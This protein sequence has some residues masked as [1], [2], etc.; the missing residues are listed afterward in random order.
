MPLQKFPVVVPLGGAVDEGTVTEL[1]Q[2]PRIQEAQDC[3]SI[4]GGA[5][6]KRDA[7]TEPLIV[8]GASVAIEHTGQE[9]VV[10]QETGVTVRGDNAEIPPTPPTPTPSGGTGR[11]LTGFRVTETDAVKQHGDQASL[12]TDTGQTR[13]LCLWNVDASGTTVSAGDNLSLT[14]TPEASDVI[15]RQNPTNPANN[16]GYSFYPTGGMSGVML[17]DGVPIGPEF[18]V[19]QQ[20]AFPRVRA[21]PGGALGEPPFITFSNL[22]VP[23]QLDPTNV[24]V[25]RSYGAHLDS[26]AF[27]DA[28][29]SPAVAPVYSRDI[30]NRWASSVPALNWPSGTPGGRIEARDIDGAI[31][32]SQNV[33]S[34]GQPLPPAL[35][36]VVV[37]G[38]GRA[39]TLHLDQYTSLGPGN[40]SAI[41]VEWGL[42]PLVALNTLVVSNTN[43]APSGASEYPVPAGLHDL[44]D[45]R[46][47]LVWSDTTR[48]VI[49]RTTF[50]AGAQLP[51]FW[52][53]GEVTGL[54]IGRGGDLYD[55]VLY[56]IDP[57][58]IPPPPFP[59]AVRAGY[60]LSRGAWAGSFCAPIEGIDGFWIG[61]QVFSDLDPKDLGAVGPDICR[62]F[63][64]ADYSG[65][66][67][68]DLPQNAIPHPCNIVHVLIT[69]D[70]VA[71]VGTEGI[72]QG[73]S[74]LSQG[75][76]VEGIGP[77]VAIT[78]TSTGDDR[79]AAQ[80]KT[81]DTLADAISPTTYLITRR[82]L[83]GIFN[84]SPPGYPDPDGGSTIMANSNA[85]AVAQ[86]LPFESCIGTT[87]INPYQ[88]RVNLDVGEWGTRWF[89]F[90]RY[91][92]QEDRAFATPPDYEA[93][94]D[95]PRSQFFFIGAASQAAPFLLTWEPLQKAGT[96]R[97]GDYAL[98]DGAMPVCC[99]TTRALAQGNGLQCI[100][101]AIIPS[102]S[103]DYASQ[104]Y[105]P[106]FPITA[107]IADG[108]GMDMSSFTTTYD[109][110]GGAHRSVPYTT[111]NAF[112]AKPGEAADNS[113]AT[114]AARL[115]PYPWQIL[116]MPQSQTASI[117]IYAVP[118]GDG[119]PLTE[120]LLIQP[121]LITHEMLQTSSPIES[122]DP[123]GA[124][125]DKRGPCTDGSSAALYTEGGELSADAPAPSIAQAIVNNRVWSLSGINRRTAQYSKLLRKGYAPEW[126]ANLTVRVPDTE[127]PLTAIGALPDGRILLF[128]PTA[129]YYT[130]G[131]GP[132]DTGQG[133]G[134]AEPQLLTDAVGCED[135]R[136]VV[137]GDFGCMFKGARGFYLVTRGLELKFVGLPYED[138]TE[139]PVLATAIDGLRSEVIFYSGQI[140]AFLQDRWVYNYLRN[141]WSSFR[142]SDLAFAATQRNGRPLTLLQFPR[143]IQA[144]TE[145]P[146]AIQP[147][148]NAGTMALKTGWLEMGRLQGFGRVWEVQLEGS[149]A[150]AS[151]SALRVEVFY[152][153]SDTAA[154]TFD[155]DDPGTRIKIRLRTARQKCEAIAFRFSEYIPTGATPELCTGWTLA[156]C[157]LLAGV[158]TGLDKIPTT[159]AN[160]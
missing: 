52:T 123:Q 134:F 31:T 143:A 132:S 11:P 109:A 154:E 56:D 139:A 4:K 148:T 73:S 77:C 7:D 101:D 110:V 104:G 125:A 137:Y 89:A 131:Q 2:P 100:M 12:V 140:S 118:N 120:A 37:S 117:G 138:T 97:A 93:T 46:L 96:V 146:V 24:T 133:A 145:D 50:T 74:I 48:H 136:S 10:F 34:T 5:Y 157:T 129:I 43:I 84:P 159:A 153:Y 14:T 40:T 150:P 147:V 28:S 58:I 112:E 61:V 27:G 156:L 106:G 130:Y 62:D 22:M 39:Y 67:E 23:Q 59:V 119:S 21:N 111:R 135:K 76:N 29:A 30:L 86:V 65:E 45:D 63:P 155:Y 116:G 69:G 115:Y 42:N 18:P 13:T 107:P 49:D 144:P 79:T 94:P 54:F 57:G 1:I 8:N 51:R 88:V 25:P 98:L 105:A 122:Y 72:I 152:D 113:S 3:A 60:R 87:M 19:A 151:E 124:D 127:E 20:Y 15:Y 114:M 160:T 82:Q 81:A 102:V 55:R 80:W 41:I 158:K 121:P 126:N 44:G 66:D 83:P 128:A 70:G 71:A 38:E 142:S 99:G 91:A 16:T 103:P 108:A 75:A 36:L 53:D 32:S 92:I 149:R 85:I 26:F 64:V 9:T 47:L 68:T 141:Q 95:P 6:E 78:A 35:E 17:E 33:D 90:Q